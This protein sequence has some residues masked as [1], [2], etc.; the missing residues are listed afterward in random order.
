MKLY[1]Q[2]ILGFIV[3]F[4]LLI[5]NTILINEVTLII[6]GQL[7]I[8]S[9]IKI[10]SDNLNGD[11]YPFDEL[12][13]NIKTIE[14]KEKNRC[15][16]PI[17]IKNIGKIR[18][19]F[20]NAYQDIQIQ[21]L[22]INF[23]GFLIKKYD[24][25]K[26]NEEFDIKNQIIVED[27]NRILNLK[28]T[29]IDPFL[30]NLNMGI[31]ILGYKIMMIR[32]L[33]CVGLAIL[34]IYIFNISG[35]IY[36]FNNFNICILDKILILTFTSI[37]IMPSV[38]WGVV[39]QNNNNGLENRVLAQKPKL[40]LQ[41]MTSFPKE[42][43]NYYN[44]N[45]PFKSKLVQLNGIIKIKLLKKSP[46]DYVVLGKDGWLFYNSKYKSDGDTIADYQGTNLYTKDE[47]LKIKDNLEHKKK[48]LNDK[49]IEFYVMI[50]PNK[51]SIYGELLPEKY[52]KNK[53]QSKADILVEY[54]I[55]NSDINVVYPKNNLLNS[56]K[57]YITYHKLDTHWNQIG[58]Y[59]GYE[60]LMKEIGIKV[61]NLNSYK[62][63]NSLDIS[64]GDLSN[65]MGVNLDF[66]DKQ[67][68]LSDMY[69]KDI[70]STLD[71]SIDT[72]NPEWIRKQ[73]WNSNCM[74]GKKLLVFRD[75][76]FTNII[77]FISKE[78]QNSTFLWQ[79]NFDEKAVEEEMPD[80]VIFEVVERNID[81]LKQ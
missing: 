46:V 45:L 75:S 6:E 42:Y 54:L 4:I 52:P 69:K 35:L 24:S 81:V 62:S 5:I 28:Q 8:N 71:S 17:K 15:E 79:G 76:F 12:N 55:K 44:D 16:I 27:K 9:S 39:F 56:K 29:G 7:P 68:L 13:T 48:L 40:T 47:L 72:N 26:I 64:Q 63:I 31:K 21:S 36:K 51:S 3:A 22:K 41:N 32:I 34:S 73:K 50:S 74:N 67:Y 38:L 19:D 2:F 20:E 25:N 65:M 43:E 10:Y 14:E 59:I 37:L 30:A 11:S 70:V 61:E 33:Y 60:S 49:G 57:D 78:F 23:A 58:A 53:S 77:P 66:E 18:I 1:K 80:V